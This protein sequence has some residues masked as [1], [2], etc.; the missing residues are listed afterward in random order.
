MSK[1]RQIYRDYFD[2]DISCCEKGERSGVRTSV[3]EDRIQMR[4]GKRR[5]EGNE[6]KEACAII[7]GR[8]SPL[9][10][11]HH[12]DNNNLNRAHLAYV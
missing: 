6:R 3:G 11:G 5:R 8:A 9:G 2:R 1:W 12:D 4:K 7:L 10:P